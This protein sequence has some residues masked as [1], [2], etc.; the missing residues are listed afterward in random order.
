MKADN[1]RD[2]DITDRFRASSAPRL[3]TGN[4]S[5][6]VERRDR[7]AITQNRAGSVDHGVVRRV[8][9]RIKPHRP[10]ECK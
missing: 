4:A 2:V 5:R 1:P 8:A 7:D 3:P 6:A 10:R 9:Q